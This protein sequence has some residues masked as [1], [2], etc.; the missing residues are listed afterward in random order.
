M[1]ISQFN[2]TSLQ[3][4]R[5]TSWIIEGLVSTVLHRDLHAVSLAII[6]VQVLNIQL[7]KQIS[8]ECW[9]ISCYYF[10]LLRNHYRQRSQYVSIISCDFHLPPSNLKRIEY[11]IIPFVLLN[12]FPIKAH[13]RQLPINSKIRNY[14]RV[15]CHC[16]RFD[17][18]VLVF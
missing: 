14:C 5:I 18:V 17:S 13:P 3:L 4:H 16:L 15:N 11:G 7:Y 10:W 9:R 1:N 8:T 2:I 6:I 12:S